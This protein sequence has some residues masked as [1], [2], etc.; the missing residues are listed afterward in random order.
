[1]QDALRSR[2]AHRGSD[3]SLALL[4]HCLLTGT[5]SLDPCIGAR[6]SECV[7]PLCGGSSLGLGKKWDG[8]VMVQLS[9]FPL[10]AGAFSAAP[11]GREG[12]NKRTEKYPELEGTHKGH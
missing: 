11:K 4:W 10:G 6:K 1:M 12:K 9:S 8:W 3:E 2:E 7:T 5:F